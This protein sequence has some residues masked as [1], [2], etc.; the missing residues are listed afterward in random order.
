[1]KTYQVI[2][3]AFQAQM[4]SQYLQS[5]GLHPHIQ[6]GKEY[7]S[8][9]TGTDLGRYEI[10]LPEEE[11]T[12]ADELLR[13]LDDP[14]SEKNHPP[15]RGLGLGAG[16]ALKRSIF[17]ALISSILLPVVL[18]LSSLYYLKR[19]WDLEPGGAKR[20]LLSLLILAFN[21]FGLAVF[22]LA[23]RPRLF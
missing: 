6:G 10:F 17:F 15:Q 21:A 11:H 4:I 18:N 8:I 16:Q 2:S 3:S 19:W 1:M 12:K 22:F 23:V 13:A 9:V 20:L 7:A 5:H 14:A